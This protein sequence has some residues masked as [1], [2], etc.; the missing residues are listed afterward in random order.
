MHRFIGFWLL[1]AALGVTLWGCSGRTMPPPLQVGYVDTD[2]IL[3]DSPAFQKMNQQFLLEK[4]ALIAREMKAGRR[5][6]EAEQ[7][8]EEKWR[9]KTMAFLDQFAT[10][11]Q[12]A[13]DEVRKD[14]HL[15]IVMADTSLFPTREWGGVDIT[16]DVHL[17]MR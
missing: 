17:R 9:P 6:L 4:R 15:D 11:I 13:A 2:A 12:D 14:K 7:V 10:Q 8:F 5:D 1:S 16:N 3:S